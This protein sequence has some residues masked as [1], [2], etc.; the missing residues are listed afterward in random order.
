MTSEVE[1]H[2]ERMKNHKGVEAVILVNK[3]GIPIRPSKGLTDSKAKQYASHINELTQKA[4]SVIREL[5]QNNDLTFLRIRSQKREIM[6]APD[7]DFTL[8]VIQ[9]P[10][11]DE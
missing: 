10:G 4:R 11:K 5:D 1:Q 8:I 6:I 2:L 3:E 9:N 7:K